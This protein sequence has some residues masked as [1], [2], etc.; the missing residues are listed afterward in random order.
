MC[1]AHFS[2][3]SAERLLLAERLRRA[4]L[5]RR[6]R[7]NRRVN[8]MQT[9][10]NQRT[11]SRIDSSFLE[12]S[13]ERQSAQDFHRDFHNQSIPAQTQNLSCLGQAKPPTAK[14][15]F[16]ASAH[17]EAQK[18]FFAEARLRLQLIRAE[19]EESVRRELAVGTGPE[20]KRP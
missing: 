12:G 17:G 13:K 10:S 1:R 11:A 9:H 14:D 6:R 4:L 8:G 20:V 18:R 3:A 16:V 2:G 15:G 5:E 19:R 7:Y